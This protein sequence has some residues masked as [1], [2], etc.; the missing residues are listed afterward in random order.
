MKQKNLFVVLAILTLIIL[1]TLSTILLVHK[2]DLSSFTINL[3]GDFTSSGGSR[4]YNASLIFQQNKLISGWERYETWPSMGSHNI[5]DCII[6]ATN[7]NWVDNA[8]KGECAYKPDYL[9]LDK[10]ELLK[11]IN[12]GDFKSIDNCRHLDI[13]YELIRG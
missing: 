10:K 9:P 2:P 4:Y 12:S 11:K 8:T 6:N 5:V 13:C 3:H 7:L 1:I